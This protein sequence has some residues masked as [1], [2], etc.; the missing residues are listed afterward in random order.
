MIDFRYHLVSIVAVFLALAIGLVLGSTEL[1]GATLDGL[2]RGTNLLNGE[3]TQARSQRD[4]YS[5]Q[6]N[7]DQSFAQANEAALLKNLLYGER[8][9]MVT[10]SGADSGTVSA[11]VS[12]AKEAGATITGTISLSGSF[13]DT[14]TSNESTLQELNTDLADADSITLSTGSVQQQAA[15]LIAEAVVTTATSPTAALTTTQ[16]QDVLTAYSKSGYLSVTPS[17]PQDLATLAIIVTPG[18]APSDGAS[19]P[20]DQALVSVAQEFAQYSTATVVAGDTSADGSGSAMSVLRASNVASKVST[21]DNADYTT[22][23]IVTIQALASQTQC[24]KAQSYGSESSAGSG[25]PSPGPTPSASVS[26]SP[27]TSSTKKAKANK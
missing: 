18:S 27:S 21:I 16:A 8:V 19:D 15:Q 17:N 6:V 2:E 7:A 11:L 20:A 22:G 23:Q 13:S 25:G 4:A 24:G 3:L 26:P 9:V 14:T 10:A 5:A 1:Q 12:A